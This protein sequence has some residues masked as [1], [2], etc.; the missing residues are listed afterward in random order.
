MVKNMTL[1]Q[2]ILSY[3]YLTNSFIRYRKTYKNYFHVMKNLLR[4]QFPITAMLRNGKEI[5]L[6]NYYETYLTSFGIFNEYSFDGS[7]IEIS[8]KDFTSVKMDLGENNGD[9]YGVFFEQIYDF[10]PVENKIVIDIGANIGDS[11]IYFALKGAKKVIALEPISK[12]YDLATKNISINNLENNIELLLAGC[13]DEK[14]H[15]I[16]DMDKIGAGS[17]L[18]SSKDGLKIP[19][20]PLEEILSKYNVD[21]AVLKFDCEGC[22]YDSILNSDDFTLKKFSHIQIEY[23]YGYQNLKNKLEKCGFQVKV[24]DPY[25]IR[26]RQAGTSMYCGYLYAEQKRED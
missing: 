10:L 14:G 11:S 4:K 17:S 24:S 13:S 12:N 22:E 1:K 26:N 15:L 23:H 21:S 3:S 20:Y 25:F 9:I 8:T 16:V 18:T 19:V 5:K 2:Y 6:K 7:I